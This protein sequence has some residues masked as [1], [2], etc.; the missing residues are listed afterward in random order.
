MTTQ[1]TVPF[2]QQYPSVAQRGIDQSTW[3]ALQ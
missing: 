2:E 3:G 1:P